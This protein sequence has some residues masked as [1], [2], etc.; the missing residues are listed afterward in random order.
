M[1][2]VHLHLHTAFSF[3][4]SSVRID[5]LL[6]RCTELGFHA[7][8]IT[9][10]DTLAG[11]LRFYTAAQAHGITPILGCELTLRREDDRDFIV[12]LARDLAG[13][14]NLCRLV[15]CARADPK[16]R[17]V[18]MG[19]LA[20]HA[21]G[22]VALY[23]A[24]ES[25]LY[26][27][28]EQHDSSRALGLV[29]PLRE[30]F[31]DSLDLDVQNTFR[32]N[33]QHL[34]YRFHQLSQETALRACVTGGV[35][36]LLRIDTELREMLA[37]LGDLEDMDSRCRHAAAS[38]ESWFRSGEEMQAL[39]AD[40]P[41][42]VDE[43]GRLASQCQ[44]ELPLHG[45]K[46]PAPVS[47]EHR[48][49]REIAYAGAAQKYGTIRPSVEERLEHEL[50]V[51]DS[52]HLET[53]FLIVRSIVR[54]AQSR[55]IAY[56]GRGSCADSLVCYCLD[57]TQVDPLAEGLLFERFLNEGRR[58]LPDVD[59]DF[60][61]FRRDE[62]IQE[63]LRAYGKEHACRIANV[64]TYNIRGAFRDVGKALGYSP[65]EIDEA[66]NM[67]PWYTDRS[68][69]ETIA[70]LPE[71]SAFPYGAIQ[72]WV[73]LA[74]R[75][76]GLPR[77]LSTHLAGVVIAPFPL[78]DLLPLQPSNTGC[79]ATQYDKD[80]I[81]RLGLIKM[82]LL[83]LRTLS[84][85]A[86]AVNMVNADTGGT[87]TLQTIPFSDEPT[88]R[89]IRSART[90]GVFQLESPGERSL[91]LKM[92]PVSQIDLAITTSLFRPGPM[93][94][95]LDQLY[96]ARR[97]GREPV[98]YDDP[99]LE[100]ALRKTSGVII[101]QEQ[102]LEVAHAIAGLSYAE[103]DVLRRTMTEKTSQQELARF[104]RLFLE[105]AATN[106]TD[107]AAAERIFQELKSF[108]AYGFCQ[109]H[110]ASFSLLGWRTA[111]LKTHWPAAYCAALM[112]AQ[113][114]GF[115]PAPIILDEARRCKVDVQK[116]SI[117]RSAVRSTAHGMQLLLGLQ[118]FTILPRREAEAI[119]AAREEHPFVSLQDFQER[120]RINRRALLH[121]ILAGALEDFGTPLTVAQ[122][123]G[124]DT[125]A[126]ARIFRPAADPAAA[127]LLGETAG[128]GYPVSV[129]LTL[130][131]SLATPE[132]RQPLTSRQLQSP[133]LC[134]DQLSSAPNGSSAWIRGIV[135]RVQTPPTKS[136]KRVFFITLE[137][138]QGMIE[139]TMFPDVQQHYAA[140][141]KQSRLLRA[142]GTVQN[143]DG[144]PV[145]TILRVDRLRMEL[146]H[147]P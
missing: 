81:E 44:V 142:W 32:E 103:A 99:R 134:S 117:L 73:S 108:A 49:L 97:K 85:A 98:T 126:V 119:V 7:C 1:S 15:T 115:Y 147:D 101:W 143:D 31:G 105:R 48:S 133:S 17:G 43:S 24:P 136:G 102:V 47:T 64:N 40:W 109:G 58:S 38:P 65:E 116:P 34:L 130:M 28:V 75:I 80:D 60:D 144:A 76:M 123:L 84:A 70:E 52:L 13:Y 106:G 55:G 42:A 63:V 50:T 54:L 11:A 3:H 19:Q 21:G 18:T 93:K 141:L 8:A 57:V 82:D 69:Q 12:L 86:D 140:V 129:S 96:L 87:L 114:V 74:Q 110:A 72:H 145:F 36:H 88:Y 6:D 128:I 100:P 89:T 53:Y 33:T 79:Q 61:A 10:L 121:L 20:E 62:L 125:E 146:S 138:E 9:D 30:L 39:F 25:L 92:Q 77:G 59:I 66:T 120:V 27:A 26:K 46:T 139:A 71:L 22:L 45:F 83:G 5:Q 68:L 78:T 90:L 4:H 2:F 41:E 127:A 67:L 14:S 122:E 95:H 35:T 107:P 137:D 51:I 16:C 94:L 132:E 104:Q 23:G 37:A 91:L 112:N 113:P 135:V 29:L 111:Y 118:T 56:S 131:L 124:A